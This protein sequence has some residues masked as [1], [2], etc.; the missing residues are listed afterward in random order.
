[1]QRD[2]PLRQRILE[3]LRGFEVQSA[4]AKGILVAT[5]QGGLRLLSVQREGKNRV[6]AQAF[7]C[8]CQL[9]PGV[10]LGL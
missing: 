10:R 3:Q 6:S 8:G 7:C 1:M 5:G 2:E 4:D 9:K